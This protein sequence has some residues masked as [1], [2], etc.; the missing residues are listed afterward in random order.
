MG[1]RLTISRVYGYLACLI[2]LITTLACLDTIISASFDLSDP[3]HARGD[4]YETRTLSS[5]DN[6]R[7]ETIARIPEGQDVPDE[8]ALDAM[9]AA[10]RDAIVRTVRLQSLRALTASGLVTIACIGIFAGHW[11]WLRRLADRAD[12]GLSA[13]A[14]PP[15]TTPAV[16]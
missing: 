6:F 4:A 7:V 15:R 11:R 9:Y 10:A 8:T 14:A 5:L 12:D 3:L 2:A 16:H 1:G 13:A